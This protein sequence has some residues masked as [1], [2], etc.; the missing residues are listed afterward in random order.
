MQVIY[1]NFIYLIIKIILNYVDFF[2]IIHHKNEKFSIKF[3]IN[4]F[5]V[6]NTNLFKYIFLKKNICFTQVSSI[7]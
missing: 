4:L 2:I 3:N 7:L 5:Y 1:S 6:L